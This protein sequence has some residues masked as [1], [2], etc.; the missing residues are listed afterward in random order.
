MT[1][2]KNKFFKPIV[3]L[4]LAVA[5]TGCMVKPKPFEDDEVARQAQQDVSLIYGSQE[6]L[7]N[8]ITLTEAMARA[9]KYNLDNRV[10]LIEQAVAS[11]NLE[12]AKQDMW[13]MLRSSGQANSRSNVDASRSKN[14]NTGVITTD[15]VT[16]I[17]ND[18][19]TADLRFTWNLL[20][21]GVGYLQAK[22]ETDRYLIARKT[23]QKVMLK[24]L[25]QVRAAYWKAATM[26]ELSAQADSIMAK[27]DTTLGQLQ[28]IRRERITAPLNTLND[29]R[30]LLETKEQLEQIR[31]AINYAK[32][33]LASLIN[34]PPGTDIELVV[35]SDMKDLPVLPPE[36]DPMQLELTALTNSVDYL[37]QIYN[38]RIDHIESRKSLLRLVPSIEFSYGANYD[39]N[40]YL[41]NNSWSE[42]GARISANLTGLFSFRQVRKYGKAK[43][44][45][46]A[47]RR[48]AVNMAVVAGVHLSWQEYFNS[49]RRVNQASE[50]S[51]VDQ[52]IAR[53]TLAAEQ[54]AAASPVVSIQKELKSFRSVIGHRL[55]YAQVHEAF[56]SFIVSMGL[57]P[58]PENYQQLTV[59]ELGKAIHNHYAVWEKG[60]IELFRFKDQSTADGNEVELIGPSF[61]SDKKL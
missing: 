2:I 12:L 53:I 27:V 9:L 5:V 33:E 15:P 49:V 51:S 21:F 13:P 32:V 14:I 58:V 23:R 48:L 39:S 56:G 10:K 60:D 18:R 8:P 37:S 11:G 38:V 41:V 16:S 59:E 30:V 24:I 57:N 34:V 50:I 55:A 44:Q 7:K 40:S 20:D 4:V 6:V 35:P 26:Q 1:S 28:Q 17:D 54:N 19:T 61:A 22:Q 29:I 25:Q 42:A 45:L 47:T 3:V 43:E 31:Q 52:E 36:V 46:A